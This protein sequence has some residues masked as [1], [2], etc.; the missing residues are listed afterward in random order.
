MPNDKPPSFSLE[1]TEGP[2]AGKILV[3]KGS[4]SFRV[5]R[6]KASGIQIKDPS[7]SE[8]HAEIAFHNGHWH[9]RDLDS[10]NGTKVNDEPISGIAV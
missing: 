7:V 8:K 5:G 6:T 3:P 4:L 1:V 2:S 10:S 9:I